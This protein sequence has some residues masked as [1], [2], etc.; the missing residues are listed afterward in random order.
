MQQDGW[1]TQDGRM[2]KNVARDCAFLV[3][4]DIFSS[5]CRPESTSCPVAWSLYHY[6]HVWRQIFVCQ[7]SFFT[8]YPFILSWGWSADHD[9]L[10]SWFRFRPMFWFLQV[11]FKSNNDNDFWTINRNTW[12]DNHLLGLDVGVVPTYQ[13]HFLPDQHCFRLIRC[14]ELRNQRCSNSKIKCEVIQ[15]AHSKSQGDLKSKKT[16]RGQ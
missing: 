6:Q 14:C 4:R 3:L 7:H 13:L 16:S 12:A 8:K 9:Q 15:S 1:N 2:T 11:T 5:F 10:H